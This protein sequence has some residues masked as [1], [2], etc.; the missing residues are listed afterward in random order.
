MRRMML[1]G[2]GGS[3]GKTLGFLMDELR[4]RLGD[5]W[6]RDTLPE[7]WQFVHIDVPSVA[8]TQGSNLA[9]GVQNRVDA[10]SVL[11]TPHPLTTS[12]TQS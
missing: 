11:P 4:F 10:T 8:D 12:W 5:S 7:C 2:L 1:V 3:G 6:T 9:S